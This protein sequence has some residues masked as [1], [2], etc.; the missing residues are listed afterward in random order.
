MITG[1]TPLTACF[2]AGRL[3]IVDRPVLIATHR[4]VSQLLPTVNRTK[5]SRLYP[6]SAFQ[7]RKGSLIRIL[8]ELSSIGPA[9]PEPHPPS[10]SI[11]AGA[12]RYGGCQPQRTMMNPAATA[13]QFLHM[14]FP[15]TLIRGRLNSQGPAPRRLLGAEDK[16]EP[17]NT[18]HG[19]CI[20]R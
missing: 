3:H 20:H 13:C 14:L 10:A 15:Y 6:F 7:M 19:C 8:R 16:E 4:R 1:D 18:L 5:E 2:A 9:Q 17:H 11:G 12:Q